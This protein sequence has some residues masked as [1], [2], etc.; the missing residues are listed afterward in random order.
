MII[1][2]CDMNLLLDQINSHLWH[3]L[4]IRCD[5]QDHLLSVEDVL[6]VTNILLKNAAAFWPKTN[7]GVS[8][9]FGGAALVNQSYT[10]NACRLTLNVAH[11]G[12]DSSYW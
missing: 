11:A 2:I 6:L 1:E 4:S 8:K 3:R 9:W 5:A 12:I 10:Q 7:M